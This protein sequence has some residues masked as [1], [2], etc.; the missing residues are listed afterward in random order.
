MSAVLFDFCTQTLL[1]THIRWEY[2]WP[3]SLKG[4]VKCALFKASPHLF[5]GNAVQTECLCFLG[6]QEADRRPAFFTMV[7]VGRGPMVPGMGRYLSGLTAV[8]IGVSCSGQHGPQRKHPSGDCPRLLHEP[9]P[10]GLSQ[11]SKCIGLT[12]PKRGFSAVAAGAELPLATSL[13]AL[14][15]QGCGS[16]WAQELLMI[17]SCASGA[18]CPL[19]A[20]TSA[21]LA[22]EL[23]P[24]VLGKGSSLC[25]GRG[26]TPGRPYNSRK[27]PA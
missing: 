7:M 16:P 18:Q 27:R 15:P 19:S 12:F 9:S 1:N 24:R 6:T 25:A 4:K 14:G 10:A 8:N 2:T 11:L 17:N 21:A 22:L 13:K 23:E 26:R 20:C 3:P 5:L